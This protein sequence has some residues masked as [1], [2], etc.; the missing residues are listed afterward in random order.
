MLPLLSSLSSTDRMGILLV[1]PKFWEVGLII[2]HYILAMELQVHVSRLL[3]L[4]LDRNWWKQLVWCK[5]RLSYS[6]LPSYLAGWY[7]GQA[8]SAQLLINALCMSQMVQ[9]HLQYSLWGVLPPY[10]F[11]GWSAGDHSWL[12]SEV[13]SYKLIPYSSRIWM[14]V[15][16]ITHIRVSIINT[17]LSPC[18]FQD[19]STLADGL[20]DL[21][22]S[23]F[24][25]SYNNCPKEVLAW[26]NGLKI[27]WVHVSRLLVLHPD[28]D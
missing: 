8:Q 18:P 2:E 15:S 22:I 3:M 24:G 11:R 7:A 20:V 23:S 17:A 21:W 12:F 6:V 27:I 19:C 9:S 26:K 4:H 10:V 25:V 13:W 28:R 5:P 1:D 14:G 16:T